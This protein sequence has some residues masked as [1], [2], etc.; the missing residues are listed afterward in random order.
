MDADV[1]F[2]IGLRGLPVRMSGGVASDVGWSVFVDFGLNEDGPYMRTSGPKSF[3]GGETGADGLP[4]NADA[5]ALDAAITGP[6]NEAKRPPDIDTA[7]DDEDEDTE[8]DGPDTGPDPDETPDGWADINY[9]VDD[10]ANFSGNVEP[11]MYL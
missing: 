3:A 11:G 2:D 5:P 9:L 4:G 1:P 10:D 8:Q 7:A 6:E